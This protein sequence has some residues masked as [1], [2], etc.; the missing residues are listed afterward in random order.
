[1]AVQH[2]I[3]TYAGVVQGVG[4]RYI[5][6]RLADQYDIIGYVRNMPDGTV[7]IEAEAEQDR[8][9][10]FLAAIRERMGGY[11]RNVQ[12]QISASRGE[13]HVFSVRY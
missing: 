2:R 12:E 1:M 3:I 6:S 7:L 10:E 13:F 4:F 5:A 9:E 11:I 8:L